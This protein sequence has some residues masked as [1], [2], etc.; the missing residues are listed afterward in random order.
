MPSFFSPSRGIKFFILAISTLSLAPTTSTAT[1][2]AI[3][4][5]TKFVQLQ[6]T[7]FHYGPPRVGQN[8][9]VVFEIDNNES[10]TL[11]I[12]CD[13]VL[14]Y[15]PRIRKEGRDY[16]LVEKRVPG[17][18]SYGQFVFNEATFETNHRG[19]FSSHY[20]SQSACLEVIGSIVS[21]LERGNR[22]AVVDLRLTKP[23][24]ALDAQSHIMG[25]V[26]PLHLKHD[27]KE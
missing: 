26:L 4:D 5:A 6:I 17:L 1:V 20:E 2:E 12:I 21:F 3:S 7:G 23:L 14:V 15:E 25:R 24:S 19:V 16:R 13:R 27:N 11:E 22:A 10:K 9:P 8:E 18:R